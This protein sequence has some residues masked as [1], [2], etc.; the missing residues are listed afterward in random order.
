MKIEGR[1]L[2]K[3]YKVLARCFHGVFKTETEVS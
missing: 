2:S 1:L 3:R